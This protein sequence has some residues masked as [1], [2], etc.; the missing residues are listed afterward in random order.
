MFDRI[1]KLSK[2]EL[3]VVQLIA[4]EVL[5]SSSRFDRLIARFQKGHFP[6]VISTLGEGMQDGSI[7]ARLP[8]AVLFL[9]TVAVGAFPQIMRHVLVKRLPLPG[10]EGEG[11]T[12]QLVDVLFNGIG[13]RQAAAE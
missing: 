4:R 6:L 9:C 1:G 5:V 7:D 13:A 10:L 12:E 3:A 11:F 8:P 2:L